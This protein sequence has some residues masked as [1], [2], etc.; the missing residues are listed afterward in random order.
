[1]LVIQ[2]EK[3]D[4]ACACLA[5]VTWLSVCDDV[6]WLQGLTNLPAQTRVYAASVLRS[7]LLD[8]IQ[9]QCRRQC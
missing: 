4:L 2:N 8:L 3:E 7:M 9:L 1:M 5:G 6:F